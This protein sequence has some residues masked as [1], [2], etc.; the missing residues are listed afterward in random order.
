MLEPVYRADSKSA[1]R[2]GMWVRLPP[3]APFRIFDVECVASP[4]DPTLCADVPALGASYSYLL[5]LYLGDGHL[6]RGARDVWKLRVTLDKRYPGIIAACGAA[7]AD[8][9]SRPSGRVRKPGCYD[10]YSYWKHWPC[11]FPQHGP[12]PKHRRR[13]QLVRWQAE[14]VNRYPVAFVTGLIHS[15]G[16]RALNIVKGHSYPRYFFSNRSPDILELFEL[17]CSL[18]GVEHRRNRPNC[19]SVARRA[20][21][22]TLDRLVGAKG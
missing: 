17:A 19:V 21:V 14:L 11:L 6:S 15:D 2:E 5:G 12:G 22:E 10:V 3:A 18:I 16:C 20:S 7:I 13:I 8:I 9:R 4:P 1:A